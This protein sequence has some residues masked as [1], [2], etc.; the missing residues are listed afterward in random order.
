MGKYDYNREEIEQNFLKIH[1]YEAWIIKQEQEQDQKEDD[2]KGAEAKEINE[3]TK[4]FAG[5]QLESSGAVS[6]KR[7][8]DSAEE[9]KVSSDDVGETLVKKLKEDNDNS[10]AVEL[11]TVAIEDSEWPRFEQHRIIKDP[12]CF[13]CFQKYRDPEPSDLVMYLHALSYKVSISDA[14]CSSLFRIPY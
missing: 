2:E 12:E 7:K 5:I 13:E 8:G 1:T 10:C 6:H 9:E 4:D 3:D 11:K 14:F